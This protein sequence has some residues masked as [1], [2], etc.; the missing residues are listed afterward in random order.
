MLCKV[1]M[2]LSLDLTQFI[3]THI[4]TRMHAH[5]HTYTH[6]IYTCIFVSYR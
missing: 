2:C 1:H 4:H 6:T 3:P 5:T